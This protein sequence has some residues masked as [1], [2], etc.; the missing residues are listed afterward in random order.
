MKKIITILVVI[1]ITLSLS[2]QNTFKYQVKANGGLS[3]GL[4]GEKVDSAVVSAGNIYFYQAGVLLNH[5]GSVTADS[6]K[7]HVINPPAPL[8][9]TVSLGLNDASGEYGFAAG[10]NNEIISLDSIGRTPAQNV[11]MG[12]GNTVTGYKST[13]IGST[14]HTDGLISTGVGNSNVAS[15]NDSFVGGNLNFLGRKYFLKSSAGV[16]DP[17]LGIGNRCYVIIAASYG[18]VRK[19]FPTTY[20]Y[21]A[22]NPGVK[23]WSLAPY[24]YVKGNEEPDILLVRFLKTTYDAVNGTKIWYDQA[25]TPFVAINGIASSYSPVLPT[26]NPGGNGQFI[27]GRL[28]STWGYGAAAVGIWNKAWRDGAFAAGNGNRVDAVSGFA[29]GSINVIDTTGLYSAAFGYSNTIYG[30]NAFVTGRNN[31]AYAN[32]TKAEG[33]QSYAKRTYQQSY[34]GEQFDEVGDA[35]DSRII[36]RGSYAG[37]GWHDFKIIEILEPNRTYHIRTY[38]TGRQTTTT[39]GEIGEST[40]YEFSA[41]FSTGDLY[42]FTNEDVNTT[43]NFISLNATA[44]PVNER[45]QFTQVGTIPAGISRDVLYYVKAVSGDSIQVSTTQGGTTVDITSTG[46]GSNTGMVFRY[47]AHVRTLKF[48]SFVNDGDVVGDGTTSGIRADISSTYFN[49]YSVRIRIDGL[50]NRTIRWVAVTNFTEI[51][52]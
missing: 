42:T 14:G 31:V 32:F 44:P 25:T 39:V 3:V 1:L 8:K 18:D 36:N 37:V 49:G 43:T 20:S 27:G 4:G 24:G 40:G 48:R 22:E 38:L 26:Y 17:G 19:Y 16:D 33:Y 34:A 28:C 35:Q 9:G 6:V 45:F 52:D 46:S 51:K 13:Y 15:A 29:G 12:N 30:S 2:A 10:Y 11:V 7:T 47:I 41:G 50:A 23:T 21:Y 5:T